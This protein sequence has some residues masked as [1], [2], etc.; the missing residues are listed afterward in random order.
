MTLFFRALP[1]EVE[2]DDLH[3][4]STINEPVYDD[5]KVGGAKRG[6]AENAQK[7]AADES[8]RP[9]VSAE[10]E[11]AG[12][13]LKE[14]EAYSTSGGKSAAKYLESALIISTEN[15]EQPPQQLYHTVF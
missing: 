8:L 13:P 14:C 7:Q 10:V 11:E 2:A 4:Y 1:K 5:I 15:S 6:G 9:C 3:V 12:F